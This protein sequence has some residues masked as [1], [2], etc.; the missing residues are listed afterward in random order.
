MYKKKRV[1]EML[2]ISLTIQDFYDVQKRMF[3][4]ENKKDFRKIIHE[5]ID[6]ILDDNQKPSFHVMQRRF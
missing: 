4:E 1:K 6:E 3:N 5:C 2:E